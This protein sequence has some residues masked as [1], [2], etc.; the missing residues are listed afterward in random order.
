M[1]C[2]G[3][4]MTSNFCPHCGKSVLGVGGTL[5]QNLDKLAVWHER[6]LADVQA[7]K[8]KFESEYKYEKAL[9]KVQKISKKYKDWA[10]F[11]REAMNDKVHPKMKA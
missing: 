8:N 3:E 1:K 2:C 6:R 10:E 9:K 7:R 5:L 11:V 4:E